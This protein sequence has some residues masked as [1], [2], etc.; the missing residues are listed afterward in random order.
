MWY[1][2]RRNG[3]MKYRL[4]GIAAMGKPLFNG[5]KKGPNGEPL[6]RR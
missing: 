6:S 3:Q 1:I 5:F 4:L 2:D